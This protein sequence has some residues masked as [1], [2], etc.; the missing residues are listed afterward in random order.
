MNKEINNDL[1][2]DQISDFLRESAEKTQQKMQDT[3]NELNIVDSV[4]DSLEKAKE[5]VQNQLSSL[6]VDINEND[7][8]LLNALKGAYKEIDKFINRDTQEQPAVKLRN[9]F[10]EFDNVRRTALAKE[11]PAATVGAF[12]YTVASELLSPQMGELAEK[13]EG[14]SRLDILLETN[15]DWFDG[16]NY[17]PD[18]KE[19]LMA[20]L[21]IPGEKINE[22]VTDIQE[23]ALKS[24]EAACYIAATLGVSTASVFEDATHAVYAPVL[25]AQ[26]D[27]DK[28]RD[29][30]LNSKT[31]ELQSKLDEFWKDAGM[32]EAWAKT[33]KE[34]GETAAVL[35]LTV[36]ATSGALAAVPAAAVA[37]TAATLLDMVDGDFVN[38][39]IENGELTFKDVIASAGTASATF[40]VMKV[41]PFVNEQLTQYAPK[42]SQ[43]VS[44]MGV[45]KVSEIGKIT[46]TI[47][48]AA[49]GAAD[50][51]MFQGVAETRKLIRYGLGLDEDFDIKKELKES[52]VNIAFGSAISGAGYFLK[53]TV[54]NSQV[55][56]KVVKLFTHHEYVAEYDEFS[57]IALKETEPVLGGGSYKDVKHQNTQPGKEINHMPA[58]SI[59]DISHDNGP[60]IKMDKTDHYQTASWGNSKDAV[61]HRQKQ[62]ALMK[63]GKIKEA[64]Q[65]DIDDVKSKFGSKYDEAI[66][67]M[68]AYVDEMI[69]KGAF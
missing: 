30:L 4:T 47:V 9:D 29:L 26:G 52:A 58:D 36:L 20:K 54:R 56:S 15:A 6:I 32:S 51:T 12:T 5:T 3:L 16:F 46:G 68:L 22:V 38:S 28:L 69:E 18:F 11:D 34:Y 53:E 43:F 33:I 37:V 1:E 27:Q 17:M 8:Q 64:I 41:L 55:F 59:S 42:I 63:E 14:K 66:K 2:L 67:Q 57:K 19:A 62:Q 13:A 35:G 45:E 24:A 21:S 48:K 39:I 23:T 40:A 65:M 10:D 25:L 50:A 7:N 49:I 44:S 61:E 60:A 31:D